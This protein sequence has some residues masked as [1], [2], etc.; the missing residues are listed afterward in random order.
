MKRSLHYIIGVLLG[1][2]AL[3]SCTK[4]T[5]FSYDN[6]VNPAADANSSIR[7]VNLRAANELSINGE[8]LTSFLQPT[9]EGGYDGRNTIP[10]PYFPETGRMG[11]TFTVPQRLVSA[12]G[13]A[14]NVQF[15]SFSRNWGLPLTRGFEM[16]DDYNQPKDYYFTYFSPNQGTLQDSVFEIP[17][18]AATPAKPDHFKIRLVNLTANTDRLTGPLI[19]TFADGTPVPGVGEI[20]VGKYSEY[21]ELPY[22]TYQFR[23]FTAD[24]HALP[25]VGGSARDLNTIDPQYG[26]IMLSGNRNLPVVNGYVDSY[27]SYATIRSFQPGGIYTIAAAAMPS[28]RTPSSLGSPETMVLKM[29]GY[30]IITDAEPL[31]NTYARVQAINVMYGQEVTVTVNNKQL[32]PALSYTTA[33]PYSIMIAGNYQIQ[34]KDKSGKL[35]LEK[36]LTLAPLD[37]ITAWIYAN[38]DGTAGLSL[39]ANNLSG[40]YYSGNGSVEDGTYSSYKDEFPIWIRFMHFGEGLQELTL[41]QENNLLFNPA[42]RHLLLGQPVQSAPYVMFDAGF[43]TSLQAFASQPNVLPG[44]RLRTVAALPSTA[45]IS[46]PAMYKRGVP[47]SEAGIFTVALVG[48]L[49]PDAPAAAKAKLMVFKHNQ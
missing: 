42:A 2:G 23:V 41:G 11:L 15:A 33:S 38:E 7:I 18:P 4:K 10:R 48:S 46:N 12:D 6:R 32:S 21:V 40:K 13:K 39:V 19:L 3:F 34:V 5:D 45:F 36:T 26:S 47:K 31:N 29:N 43:Y 24:G 28:F 27:L 49:K 1:T 20:A 22:G 25:G 17:R 37:N 16:K 14:H 8:Q 30:R 44:D 35:L 9:V